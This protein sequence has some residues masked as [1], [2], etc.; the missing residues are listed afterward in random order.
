M[1]MN[2]KV[3]LTI[4]N[5]LEYAVWGAYLTSMGSYLVNIGLAGNIGWFYSVQG[6]VSLFM[7]A[8]V[9]IVADRWMQGQKVLSLCHLL[10][11]AF[12]LAAAYYGFRAGDGAEFSV[13]FSLYTMSV[14]FYMPTIALGQLRGLFGARRSRTGYGEGFSAHPRVRHNRFHLFHVGG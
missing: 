14:A 12:M 9:G 13:L 1:Y 11:G 3:R 6:I 5:F 4:M 8:L 2:L 7:P 10:A